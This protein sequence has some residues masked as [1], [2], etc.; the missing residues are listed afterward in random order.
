MLWPPQRSRLLQ[1]NR[2][3]RSPRDS[4]VRDEGSGLGLPLV[5]NRI[6]QEFKHRRE[7]VAVSQS[8]GH[9]S[10]GLSDALLQCDQTGAL[11][12]LMPGWQ[13]QRR[14]VDHV[15]RKLATEGTF[16]T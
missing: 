2:T 1:V 14:R 12:A 11:L 8:D 6:N 9:E 4:A 16:N 15:Q 7:A 5:V 13:S 3:A 10:F